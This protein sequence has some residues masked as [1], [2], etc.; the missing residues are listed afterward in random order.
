MSVRVIKDYG[1]EDI[2]ASIRRMLDDAARDVEVRGL[3][4]S[5]AWDKP[6]QNINSWVKA[7]VHYVPD[8]H[9]VELFTSPS[10][11][12]REYNEGKPLVGDCDDMALL[13]VALLRAVGIRSNVVLLDTKGEGLDHAVA[14]AW[15]DK[16]G[17]WVYVD[18]SSKLPFGWEEQARSKVVV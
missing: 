18:P 4:A 8:P 9:D 13:S 6:L 7:N 16:L 1:I 3:A 10:R 5:I 11:M 2:K 15:S 14:Q 12:V 17:A